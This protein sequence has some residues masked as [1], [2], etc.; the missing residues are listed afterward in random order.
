VVDALRGLGYHVLTSDGCVHNY[1]TPW[2]GSLRGKLPAG[3]RAA[4][5]TADPVNGGYWI[6]RSDGGVDAFCA[7]WYGSVAG[8]VPA[9]Q[10]VTG[11]AGE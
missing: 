7:P 5:L 1:G 4:G 6:S 3:V 9:G 11:I 2:Y 8:Q 10:T